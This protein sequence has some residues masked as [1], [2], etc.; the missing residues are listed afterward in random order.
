MPR[1]ERVLVV[2][3]D[4]QMHVRA[5]EAEVH[6]A[7]VFAQRGRQRGLADR[8]PD[9]AAAQAADR[10]DRAE[11]DVHRVPRMQERPLL[12]RLAR[13]L[14]LRRPAGTAPLATALLGRLEQA[15]LH[16]LGGRRG[17][18]PRRDMTVSNSCNVA[19]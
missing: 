1:G 9:A 5:L 7:K 15:E 10:A 13:S 3:L 11:H 18:R 16:S 14:A 8:L 17:E 19:R 12:V 4:D 6:D 2:G